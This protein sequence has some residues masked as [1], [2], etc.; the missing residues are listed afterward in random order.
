V[1]IQVV[2]IPPRCPQ[3]NC[4]SG[5]RCFVDETYLKVWGR[6]IYLYR[7]IDQLGQVT[8]VLVSTKRDLAATRRF[9]T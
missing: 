5:D 6:W 9:F 7:A 8:D 1:G 2:R 4:F 3:G